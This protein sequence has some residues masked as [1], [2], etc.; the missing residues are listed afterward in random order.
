[1]IKNFAKCLKQDFLERC[2][3]SAQDLAVANKKYM[4]EYYEETKP[5]SHI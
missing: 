5:S 2:V 3:K 1:M 4:G